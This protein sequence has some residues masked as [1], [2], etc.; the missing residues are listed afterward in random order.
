[1]MTVM[2]GRIKISSS[3]AEG[4][5]AV[6]TVLGKGEFLGEMAILEKK[7]SSAHPTAQE[8]SDHVGFQSRALNTLQQ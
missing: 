2:K 4:K 3:S 6:L 8:P 1:M 5:E 7:K